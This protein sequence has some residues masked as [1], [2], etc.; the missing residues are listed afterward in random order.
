MAEAATPATAD[1]RRGAADVPDQRTGADG[2][3]AGHTDQA[4]TALAA[5]WDSLDVH[6]RRALLTEMRQRM[7]QRGARGGGTLQIRTERRY[8][9]IIHQP[10]GRVI[11]IETQVVHVRPISEEELLGV[12]GGFGVGFERRAGEPATRLANDAPRESIAPPAEHRD[13][14]S[15]EEPQPLF[16]H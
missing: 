7:A 16:L 14:V 6:Q 3:Y 4:L 1:D 10:D 11:R 9:R 8:G 13:R 15:A 2:A 5:Q 12:Q